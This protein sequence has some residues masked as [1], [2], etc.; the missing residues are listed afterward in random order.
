V[1]S[2]TLPTDPD[3]NLAGTTCACEPTLLV[4][5][6]EQARRANLSADFAGKAGDHLRVARMMGI[7]AAYQ[8]VAQHHGW[9]ISGVDYR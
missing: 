5:L 2:R 9:D 8:Q 1:G 6:R 4:W 7:A 3:N